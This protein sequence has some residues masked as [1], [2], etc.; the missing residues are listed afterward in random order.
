MT[1]DEAI[2]REL[3]EMTRN[4]R[5]AAAVKEH[6]QR[7]SAGAA[8]PEL[9]EMANDL[10]SGRSSM[11][12]VGKNQVYAQKLVEA[13][14]RFQAWFAKLS[15]EEREDMYDKGVEEFGPHDD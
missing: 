8:G 4:P 14:D 11:R 13:T 9:A 15:P 1:G 6:L 5:I 3:A 2:D 10:L 12:E 7:L